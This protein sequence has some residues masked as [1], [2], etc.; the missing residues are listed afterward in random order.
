MLWMQRGNAI[1]LGN[2]TSIPEGIERTNPCAAISNSPSK[3]HLETLI[4]EE[5][6]W[7]LAGGFIE[8]VAASSFGHLHSILELSPSSRDET[9]NTSE[10]HIQPCGALS[11][12]LRPLTSFLDSH[13]EC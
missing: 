12:L 4:M 6:V 2:A 11:F 1:R 9:I 8:T 3:I 13:I 10:H 7:A 5:N